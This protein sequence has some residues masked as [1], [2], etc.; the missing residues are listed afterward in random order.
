MKKY[1]YTLK[2]SANGSA[3]C[4]V[5]A[6]F[7]QTTYPSLRKVNVP[8]RAITLATS[9]V[10]FSFSSCQKLKD[11]LQVNELDLPNAISATDYT[12][13]SGTDWNF[14]NIKEDT[15]F[16]IN[17]NTELTNF[18]TG[19][20]PQSVDFTQYSL[21]FA[22]GRAYGSISNVEK[23]FVRLSNSY[24][25][26]V[27][28]TLDTITADREWH[29]A[30]L[31]PKLANN[32]AVAF[33]LY[34]PHLVVWQ[35]FEDFWNPNPDVTITLAMDTLLNNYYVST[36]PQDLSFMEDVFISYITHPFFNGR[37]GKYV[38]CESPIVRFGWDFGTCTCE[39]YCGIRYSLTMLS[40]DS[41]QLRTQIGPFDWRQYLFI[42]QNL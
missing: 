11:N 10:A 16:V 30:V 7:S 37:S 14:S 25:L 3:E 13:G 39:N 38:F 41:M 23:S 18:I 26:N 22:H 21:L 17:S 27:G 12:L 34:Y 5:C 9:I 31:V 8:M 32:T 15:L 24:M 4:G 42:H 2:H 6:N 1:I 19:N 36:I 33:N 35:C 20:V 40:P 28:I 29:L